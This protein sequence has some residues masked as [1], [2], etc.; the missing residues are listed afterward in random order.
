MVGTLPDPNGRTTR[1]APWTCPTCPPNQASTLSTSSSQ[2]S[3][4]QV[5]PLTHFFF[6]FPFVIKFIYLPGGQI[7]DPSSGKR[8]SL[9]S[10]PATPSSP[11][12]TLQ[13]IFELTRRPFSLDSS[14][15]IQ[16]HS[17][18]FRASHRVPETQSRTADAN[19]DCVF[20]ENALFYTDP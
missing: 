5:W 12:W 3:T 16:G 9:M 4:Y 11:C 15:E 8:Y 1:T 2:T 17:H 13:G 10:L 18:V 6:L 14:T 20:V 19:L 7:N